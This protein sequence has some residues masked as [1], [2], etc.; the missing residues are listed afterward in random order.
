MHAQLPVSSVQI[1]FPL[2][3]VTDPRLPG[4]H[5]LFSVFPSV[6]TPQY[7]LVQLFQPLLLCVFF[8]VLPAHFGK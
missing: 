2:G 1:Y 6:S 8:I 5:L 4:F 3:T 7:P